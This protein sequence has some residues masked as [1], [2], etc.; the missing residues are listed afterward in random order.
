MLRALSAPVRRY[1]N[2]HFNSINSN[3]ESL[4]QRLEESE[5][6]IAEQR[7]QIAEQN[8]RIQSL[9][10]SVELMSRTLT[11]LSESQQ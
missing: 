6:L 8:R 3:I 7:V 1:F 2:Y 4:H 9:L 10:I 5:R 11:Q